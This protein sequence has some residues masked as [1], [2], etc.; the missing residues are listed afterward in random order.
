MVWGSEEDSDRKAE[1]L[2]VLLATPA[3]DYDVSVPDRPTVR[4]SS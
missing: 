1:V 4:P 3:T 2:A